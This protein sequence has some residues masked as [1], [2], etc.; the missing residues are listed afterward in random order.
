[1]SFDWKTWIIVAGLCLACACT[2]PGQPAKAI[3]SAT[4]KEFQ[5][6]PKIDIPVEVQF[7][8]VNLGKD[9]VALNISLQPLIDL[10][11]IAITV[12]LPAE[13]SI[14]TGNLTWRG[15]LSKGE[16]FTH[17]VSI[18]AAKLNKVVE[19]K[20]NIFIIEGGLPV[21]KM[22]QL[23]M[24]NATEGTFEFYWNPY[25]GGPLPTPD[26]H[27]GTPLP[28]AVSGTESPSIEKPPTPNPD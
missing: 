6:L 7:E 17:Q 13:V 19:F 1:M 21:E 10:P 3:P 11:T 24:R 27:A 9:R 18:K 2:N 28:G 8:G 20:L 5:T 22:M 12:T 4:D 23:Y 15:S 25:F 26:L 14:L 16:L